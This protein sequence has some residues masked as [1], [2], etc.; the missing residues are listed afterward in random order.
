MIKP[1]ALPFPRYKIED[2]DVT[3][4]GLISISPSDP[5]VIEAEI[6]KEKFGEILV[7]R[8]DDIPVESLDDMKGPTVEHLEAAIAF[9]KGLWSKETEGGGP[10]QIAVNC[11]AG[12]SRS[13]AIALAIN[14]AHTKETLGNGHEENVVRSLLFHDPNQQMCFNPKIVDDT[15]R[16]LEN[17]GALHQA[18]H[19][20]CPP[21]RGWRHYWEKII[22]G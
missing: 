10:T 2:G 11:M 20:L 21:A 12:K 5:K 15:D 14:A 16:L 13:A 7:L 17:G 6:P 9:A 8:F 22:Q 3:A 4:M 18:L 1:I 19:K